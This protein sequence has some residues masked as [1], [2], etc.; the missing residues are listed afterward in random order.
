MSIIAVTEVILSFIPGALIAAR[1]VI[2]LPKYGPEM[3]FPW[4]QDDGLMT[5]SG[6][7]NVSNHVWI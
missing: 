2:T 3:M 6:A 5:G 4:Q 7:A 1:L